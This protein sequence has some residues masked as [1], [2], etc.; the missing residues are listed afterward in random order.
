MWKI[1]KISLVILA[2][3][4][5]VGNYHICEYFHPNDVTAWWDL[6]SNNYAIIIAL[7][8]LSCNIGSKGWLRF[9][10]SVGVGLSISNVIDKI[11]FDVLVFTNSDYFM[12][13]ATLI[14]SFWDARKS[15]KK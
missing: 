1:I 5:F 6:K 15:L 4:L 3:T 12:I 13:I 14:L 7:C 11:Y 10:L 2:I 8:F 9:F